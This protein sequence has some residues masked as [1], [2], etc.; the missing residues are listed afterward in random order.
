MIYNIQNYIIFHL[1]FL[2][3]HISNIIN[4]ISPHTTNIL[5][6][7]N[8]DITKINISWYQYR[9]TKYYQYK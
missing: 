2:D 1:K 6:N 3:L 4:N 5:I 7:F 9:Y 8:I